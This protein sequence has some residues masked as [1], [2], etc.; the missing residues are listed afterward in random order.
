MRILLFLLVGAMLPHELERLRHRCCWLGRYSVARLCLPHLELRPA[1]G[2][3]FNISALAED[4]LDEI[5]GIQT[6]QRLNDVVKT[7]SPGFIPQG[8]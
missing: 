4:A 5:N 3:N 6:R 8:R 1:R 2:K 7:G